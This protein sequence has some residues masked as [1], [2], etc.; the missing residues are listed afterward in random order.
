MNRKLIFTGLFAATIALSS[1]A[2]D[3]DDTQDNPHLSTG[4]THV[5]AM[6]SAGENGF[7]FAGESGVVPTGGTK[8]NTGGNS[9]TGGTDAS[10]GA[11]PGSAGT[12]ASGGEGGSPPELPP[13]DCVLHPK[14]HLEII[15]ACTDA[16]R[17]E[18]HPELPAIP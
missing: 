1:G 7:G 16:T 17:I 11:D 3:S 2:C 4:G 5:S 12:G 6:P 13:Y 8:G 10:A 15:N 14:T 9:S 18:K